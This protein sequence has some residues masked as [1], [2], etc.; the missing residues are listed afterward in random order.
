MLANPVARVYAEAVYAIARERSSVDATAG[1]LE[2]VLELIR[3]NAD[4]E[5]FLATPVLEPSVKIR[6]LRDA[7]AGR[8]SDLVSDFLC[9]LVE[10]RRAQALPAIVEALRALA[11]AHAG[12]AR[13]SVRT[14]APL[15]DSLRSRLEALL[16]DTLEKRIVLEA[17]LEPA[18]MGGAVVTIGDKVYDGSIRTRL[19]RFRKQITRS[20][21]H[22]TQG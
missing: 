19:A 22:E 1:E 5:R 11:D 15:P 21:G 20:G 2:E 6:H 13:V 14:A 16:A 10:K 3:G 12:R 7:L 4:I 18:L 17:A 8:V 9:L